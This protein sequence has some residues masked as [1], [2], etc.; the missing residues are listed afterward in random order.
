MFEGEEEGVFAPS[1]FF[2]FASRGLIRGGKD[3]SPF[4]CLDWP[5][6]CFFLCPHPR[7]FALLGGLGRRTGRRTD[8]QSLSLLPC[9][10][11]RV[12]CGESGGR[13]RQTVFFWCRHFL[14]WKPRRD[15]A[16]WR[17]AGGKGRRV[18]PFATPTLGDFH[19]LPF[20][21]GGGESLGPFLACFFQRPYRCFWPCR[22]MA[23][24]GHAV[25]KSTRRAARIAAHARACSWRARVE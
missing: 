17:C 14:F 8:R 4:P 10:V 5:L 13:R 16:V 12:L 3:S 6:G 21:W 11:L 20:F 25:G 2:S 22:H 9:K 24:W 7:S 18:G 15:V 23:V 19:V 1:P